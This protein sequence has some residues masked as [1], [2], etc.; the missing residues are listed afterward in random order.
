M[1]S[2]NDY[3]KGII[4][5]LVEKWVDSGTTNVSDLFS[6]ITEESQVNI[7]FDHNK[8]S[9]EVFYNSFDK[10]YYSIIRNKTVLLLS[11]LNFLENHHLIYMYEEWSNSPTEISI[12]SSS[13]TI[14]KGKQFFG[15]KL[16]D[17][18]L[19]QINYSVIA[20]PELKELVRNDFKSAE[21][22]NHEQN[23]AIQ[24]ASLKIAVIVAVGSMVLSVAAI[25]IS[26]FT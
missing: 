14:L 21:Q 6:Y 15:D 25:I 12:Y 5:L 11:L 4:Q 13:E 24:E 19:K 23:L 20:T 7:L 9:I 8:R 17:K 26:L 22:I 10:D 2:F 18:I 3:E 1:R 16:T